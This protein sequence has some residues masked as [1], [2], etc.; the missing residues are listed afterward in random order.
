M[1][2]APM[3][4]LLSTRSSL[5]QA[6][7]Q[8]VE[9]TPSNKR[10]LMPAFGLPEPPQPNTTLMT[11][12]SSLPTKQEAAAFLPNPNPKHCHTMTTTPTTATCTTSSR[13]QELPIP[14]LPPTTANGFQKLL[15][16]RP[17]ATNTDY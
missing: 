6:S 3:F 15:I 10:S 7:T 5:L 2:L 14:Q 4:I 1:G 11:S 13:H 8:Q 16:L 17:L 12:N 9:S